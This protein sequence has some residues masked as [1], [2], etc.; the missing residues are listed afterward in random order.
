[1]KV[2]IVMSRHTVLV[3][4]DNLLVIP[5]ADITQFTGKGGVLV[6]L[7]PASEKKTDT[8]PPAPDKVK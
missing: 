1:V 5:T 8:V 4:D 7:D 6:K 2:V 3:R